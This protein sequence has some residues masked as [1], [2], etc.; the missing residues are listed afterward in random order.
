MATTHKQLNAAV[1]RLNEFLNLPMSPYVDGK[2]QIGNYH[3]S[4]AYGGVALH[5]MVNETGG[6]ADVFN[7]GYMSKSKLLD[8]IHAYLAGANACAIVV[9]RSNKE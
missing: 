8:L 2:A 6:V 1:D 7:L 3:T 5:L 4:G 9:N